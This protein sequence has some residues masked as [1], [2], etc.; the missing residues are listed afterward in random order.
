MEHGFPLCKIDEPKSDT[1]VFNDNTR[2]MILQ[3]NDSNLQ[4]I[5]LVYE[6]MMSMNNQ[7]TSLTEKVYN[8]SNSIEVLRGHQLSNFQQLDSN[9]ISAINH[10]TDVV[11]NEKK[12]ATPTTPTTTKS[13]LKRK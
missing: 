4:I 1:T 6:Q 10:L 9:V 7:L 2:K 5:K 13:F 12:T 3:M 11:K 8:L